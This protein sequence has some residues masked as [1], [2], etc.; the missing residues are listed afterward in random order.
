M[1]DGI[2]G[3]NEA[4]IRYND[5]NDD[6]FPPTV[7]FMQFRD[8]NNVQTDRFAKGAD[9]VINVAV[10]DYD[11]IVHENF[12]YNWN[13]LRPVELKVEYAP[14]GTDDF[15]ELELAEDPRAIRRRPVGDIT[16]REACRLL[17]NFRLTDGLTCVLQS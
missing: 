11:N 13:E 4:E 14:Y 8:V 16:I 3:K 2:A 1:V 17:T 6:P 9:G 10:A 7:R 12:W 15:A 5:S